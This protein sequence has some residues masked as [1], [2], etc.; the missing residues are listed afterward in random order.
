MHYA[1]C[2]LQVLGSDFDQ[3][4]ELLAKHT[5]KYAKVRVAFPSRQSILSAPSVL[6]HPIIKTVNTN[7]NHALT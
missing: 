2:I 6:R 4:E 5:A 1:H 7:R 3:R